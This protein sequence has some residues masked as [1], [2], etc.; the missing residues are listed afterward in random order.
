MI[1]MN[2][3]GNI[4]KAD[5]SLDQLFKIDR[6]GVVA[7]AFGNLQH[8]RRFFL[9]TG[10]DD[11]LQQFHVVDIKRTQGVFAFKRFGE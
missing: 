4:G 2:G 11:C 3:D 9:F 5:R 1:Q 6:V 8:H 7:S 10:F